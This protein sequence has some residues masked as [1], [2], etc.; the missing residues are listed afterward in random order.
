MSSPK[1][2]TVNFGLRSN[3]TTTQKPPNTSDRTLPCMATIERS[4]V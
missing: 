4:L 3:P 1:L 2:F